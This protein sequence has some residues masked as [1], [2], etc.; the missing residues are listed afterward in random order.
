MPLFRVFRSA[1]G[2]LGQDR[3]VGQSRSSAPRVRR[4][5]RAYP[6]HNLKREHTLDR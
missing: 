1:D 3:V 4:G 2:D 5:I 6:N